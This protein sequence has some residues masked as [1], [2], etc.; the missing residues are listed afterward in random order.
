M[1]L[2][3]GNTT[4]TGYGKAPTPASA[5]PYW[6]A[7]VGTYRDPKTGRVAIGSDAEGWD[8]VTE[9]QYRAITGLGQED[10][11]LPSD[12]VTP[13]TPMTDQFAYDMN[14]YGNAAWEDGTIPNYDPGTRIT[15]NGVIPYAT[16]QRQAQ[17]YP[18][19]PLPPMGDVRR[20][21]VPSVAQ[22]VVSKDIEDRRF[23]APVPAA[24]P[25]PMPAPYTNP[26]GTPRL[27]DVQVIGGQIVR[28]PR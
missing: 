20:L 28:L 17:Q 6:D 13:S 14:T 3:D 16:N 1:A 18:T 8:W 11:F 19:V 22:G 5:P 23:P 15:P 9:E 7:S 26:D 27:A 4:A 12:M 2:V 21:N 25:T 10:D 24:A